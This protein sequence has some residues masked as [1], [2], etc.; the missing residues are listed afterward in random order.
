MAQVVEDMKCHSNNSPLSMI[1]KYEAEETKF[2]ES[3]TILKNFY[4]IAKKYSNWVS[5]PDPLLEAKT[6]SQQKKLT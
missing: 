1:S 2:K 3:Q 5:L 6:R 4:K